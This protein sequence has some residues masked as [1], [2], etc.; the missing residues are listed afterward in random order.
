MNHQYWRAVV[1]LKDATH[2]WDVIVYSMYKN[3]REA[4]HGLNMFLKYT[5]PK[6]GYNVVESWVEPMPKQ[7]VV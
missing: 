1:I 6:C 4:Q 2:E 3:M 5:V 7:E